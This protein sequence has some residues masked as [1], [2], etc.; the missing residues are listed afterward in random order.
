MT[1]LID[2]ASCDGAGG[3]EDMR[4][5][6]VDRTT[7]AASGRWVWCEACNRT[8][9]EEVEDEPITQEDLPHA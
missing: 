8:G 2:C 4:D 6:C 3:W 5:I 7:G 9:V 1:R